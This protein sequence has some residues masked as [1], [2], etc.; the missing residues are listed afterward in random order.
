MSK[1]KSKNT[2]PKGWDESRARSVLSHYDSQGEDEALAE[3]EA[4]FDHPQSTLM[5]I[6]VEL[7]PQVRELVL[8]H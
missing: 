5:E 8:T 6:P 1:P 2:F 7:L 4:M 3:D